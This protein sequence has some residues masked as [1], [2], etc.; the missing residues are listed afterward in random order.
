MRFPS[1][2]PGEWFPPF[3][4]LASSSSISSQIAAFFFCHCYPELFPP[5]SPMIKLFFFLLCLACPA[6]DTSFPDTFSVVGDRLSSVSPR[7]KVRFFF[8]T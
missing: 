8:V 5:S 1:F 4:F 6:G 7:I 2:N 3:L